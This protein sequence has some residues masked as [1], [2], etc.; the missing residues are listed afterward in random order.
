MP[1]RSFERCSKLLA[2]NLTSQVNAMKYLGDADY[3]HGSPSRLGVLMVN[4]GTPDSTE[5]KDVRRYL[6]QFLSDPRI[7]EVPRVLWWLI[8]NG[9]IL[10]IRPA[11]TAEAYK[12]V[13]DE[14]EG[15][16]LM[17]I[18][19][20]QSDALATQLG[21]G[22]HA[23]VELAMR[24]GNPSVADA[25]NRLREK[26]VR[27][28]LVLP[29]YPQY[30]GSTVASV[31]DEVTA[32]LSKLRWIP[33]CRFIN[34]YF[35]EQSYIDALALSVEAHWQQHGKPQQLIMSYHGIPQ[36]YRTNGD[37]YFCQCQATSRLLADRLQLSDDQFQVVFQSRFGKE[38]WLQPYCDETLK[39]LPA[40][41]VRDIQVI[42]PGFS[43]DCLE[44]IE[45]IDEEN[46][47]YFIE[48]GGEK[49][50]Y[51]PALNEQAMHIDMMS[52]LI[53]R[54][55]KGWPEAEKLDVNNEAALTASRE[56]ALALGAIA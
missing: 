37:P 51:I 38:P 56:R 8:L 20:K 45:E 41:G 54:H 40:K 16:P 31:F 12:S 29:M 50:S 13:W 6:K 36:R 7:V 4:L 35:D 55:C 14:N 22:L 49:F 39:S 2:S 19:R 5:V 3:Q 33:E 1:I 52:A 46:K 11:K 34:Q 18:S 30:S 44:T 15:S 43:A 47:E 42:C 9:V 10:R 32:K 17:S 27:R 28:L 25:L 48:A 24:Y 26:N 21:S 23:E 53:E